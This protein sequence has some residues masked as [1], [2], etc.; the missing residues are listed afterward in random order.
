MCSRDDAL[1]SALRVRVQIAVDDDVIL[2]AFENG[3]DGEDRKRKTAILRAD[4]ARMK[5]E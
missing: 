5:A 4:G 3:G 1:D 2:L